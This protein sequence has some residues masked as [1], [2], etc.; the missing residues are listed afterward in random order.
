M[1]VCMY[2]CTYLQMDSLPDNAGNSSVRSKIATDPQ[3]CLSS[4]RDWPSARASPVALAGRYTVFLT[5]QIHDP[6]DSSILIVCV[7][8]RRILQRETQ[9]TQSTMFGFS[10]IYFLFF[11]FSFF[12]SFLFLFFCLV[13]K[14]FDIN[15]QKETYLVGSWEYIKL[16]LLH[17]HTR[18]EKTNTGEDNTYKI[19]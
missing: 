10:F 5:R 18:T 4:G 16:G 11:L 7:S 9:N 15:I 3:R 8:T 19:V 1:Y 6:F 14:Q 13:S 17:T 12:F 2:V